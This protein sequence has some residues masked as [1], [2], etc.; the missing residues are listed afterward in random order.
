MSSSSP[1]ARPAGDVDP[2]DDVSFELLR[3]R[4]S[5]KWTKY[6][7]DVLPAWVAEMDFALALPIR[8]VLQT[9]VARDDAGYADIGRLP[10]AFT[11]FA[12]DRFGWTVEP[13][14]VRLVADVMSAVAALLRAITEPGEGVVINPP[15]YPPFAAVTREV[16]RVVV[17]APLASDSSVDLDAL[18][19]AFAAGARAYLLCHPHNPTGRACPREEL[20]AIAALAGR[21]GVTVIADEVHAPMTLPGAAHV[22]Y[23]AVGEE[24]AEL[25]IA[26]TSASKAWNIAGLKSAVIVTASDRM[27]GLLTERLPSHLPYH[28]GHFGVLAAIAAF[29]HG[30]EWLDALIRHLDRN[31]AF[32]GELLAER[33]PEVG[34]TPPQAG[35]LAWLDCRELDLGDDPSEAFLAR[36]RVALSPG[37]TFGP[38]GA[39]FAR[40]NIGTSS[41]LLEEAVRRMAAAVGRS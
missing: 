19:Q 15:V 17:E 34:Y 18:E 38:G 26:I 3:L 9:A 2:F 12:G 33:L 25:G 36:G 30:S 6:P 7:S 31:R 37:P 27:D 8:E 24:A 29:E 14:R 11:A 20:A 28:A 10:T 5:A 4:R 22:P 13:G 40:L 23:L 1:D 21:Y 32:L 39:G 35:Y 41:A 16:G